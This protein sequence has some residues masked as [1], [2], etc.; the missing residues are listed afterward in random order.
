MGAAVGADMAAARLDRGAPERF[1]DVVQ[2]PERLA[3]C[4]P[5][6]GLPRKAVSQVS[7]CA[8][9]GDRDYFGRDG[10][11]RVCCRGGVG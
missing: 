4:F 7:D 5:E 2:L 9:V 1:F 3:R 6:G 8:H 11:G 10:T